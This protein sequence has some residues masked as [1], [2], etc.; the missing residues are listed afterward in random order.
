M[1]GR[2]VVFF[3]LLGHGKNLKVENHLTKCITVTRSNSGYI[4]E[5][6]K[7]IFSDVSSTCVGVFRLYESGFGVN[8]CVFLQ[9]QTV[10][11][12]GQTP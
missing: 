4:L 5:R 12:L 7:E 9:L 10:R 6:K 8:P 2:I 11:G 1:P 3:P